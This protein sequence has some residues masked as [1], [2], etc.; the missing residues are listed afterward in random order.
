MRDGAP[1]SRAAPRRG[2]NFVGNARAPPDPTTEHLKSELSTSL[3]H[4]GTSVIGPYIP[5]MI[6]MYM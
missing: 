6:Y 2:Y 5:Y 4:M 3:S 1:D